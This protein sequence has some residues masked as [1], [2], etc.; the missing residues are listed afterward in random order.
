[1]THIGP[2]KCTFL[3]F[4][5]PRWRTAA[6]F[7]IDNLL[8]LQNGSTDLRKIWRG[9]ANC[10]AKPD[11][12]LKFTTFENPRWRTAAILKIENWPYLR[13]GSTNLHEIWYDDAYVYIHTYIYI[14]ASKT[15]RKLKFSTF[16]NPRWRS[17]TDEHLTEQH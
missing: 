9:D 7:K 15:D 6:I 12:K 11:R 16:E 17:L 2:P 14:T 1:M 13:N 3:T 10:A 5:N 8:Y 4:K